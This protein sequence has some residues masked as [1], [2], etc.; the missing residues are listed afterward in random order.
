MKQ[1]LLLLVLT[2]GMFN[3]SISAQTKKATPVKKTTAPQ[4][5]TVTT[6]KER[7]VGNDG[8]IWYLLKK[9]EL[10]GVQ[11]IEGNEIIPVVYNRIEY[12]AGRTRYFKVRSGD[13]VGVYTR[14]GNLVISTDK[15]YTFI[16][17]GIYG[18]KVKD[19][20]FWNVKK[21]DGEGIIL[22][23]NGKEV[24]STEDYSAVSMEC[25]Y[26][27]KIT[28]N[29]DACYFQVYSND[30]K[31]GIVGLDGKVICPPIYYNCAIYYM[32]ELL[33]Y[34]K[35]QSSKYEEKE[36]E[37]Y[38]YLTTD[39]H[40][41]S[42]DD[43]RNKNYSSRNNTSSLIS[44]DSSSSSSSSNPSSSST[45]SNSGSGTTQTVVVEHHRDPVPVQE[46]QACFGC[47][48]MGTMGCDFCGGSGTRYVG[49]NLRRCSRCNGQGIIPCNICYGNK[50][51]YVTVYR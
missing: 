6:T 19:M 5:T 3:I 41:N 18:D 32:G 43:L 46:W 34:K 48:G 12:E 11:D 8:F 35:F 38:G 4:S 23:A 7:Q 29:P 14:K 17:E 21:N 25:C 27:D 22:D 13:F 26:E 20:V 16:I 39:F 51:K 30:N 44:S 37:Y 45:N 50:G 10:Y 24:F 47:G 9:G 31:K 40:Y 15:H 33:M 36:I 1:T 2:L 49:D 28:K 42:Y